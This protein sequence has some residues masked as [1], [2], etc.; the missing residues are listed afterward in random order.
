M[1]TCCL[2][3]TLFSYLTATDQHILLKDPDLW[4]SCFY[5]LLQKPDFRYQQESH[6]KEH[7]Y[8]SKFSIFVQRPTN[9]GQ[10]Q[11]TIKSTRVLEKNI[12]TCSFF[13][14]EIQCSTRNFISMFLIFWNTSWAPEQPVHNSDTCSSHLKYSDSVSLEPGGTP[15][16]QHFLLSPLLYFSSQ[17]LPV[18]DI[19]DK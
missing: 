9:G 11:Q 1:I 10:T 6:G 2:S 16:F 18:S 7:E 3:I 17:H 19:L 5:H 4:Y 12:N 15:S 8:A 14:Y 13:T